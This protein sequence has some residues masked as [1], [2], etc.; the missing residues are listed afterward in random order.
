MR[1]TSLALFLALLAPVASAR[2]GEGW[3]PVG[4][5]GGGGMF[6][7]AGSPADPNLMMVHCDMSAAYVSRDAGRSW[8]MVHHAQLRGCTSCSPVFH[9]R[10]AG[11]VYSGSGWSGDVR[12][13]D[14]AGV[15]WRPLPARPPRAGRLRA[16]LRSR[17]CGDGGFSETGR[18]AVGS[19]N[20]TAG[21]RSGTPSSRR[22]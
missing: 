12:V 20:A 21:T 4:L 3:R 1:R 11:R 19:T 14:D 10:Q 15:T 9:P 22:T 6:S 17:R 8:R 7:L 5:C 16:F 13:S 18:V 2:A